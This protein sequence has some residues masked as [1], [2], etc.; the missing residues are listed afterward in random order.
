[1]QPHIVIN[2]R[3]GLPADWD[4]PEQEIG[5]FQNNRAWESCITL[6]QQW[7]WKPDD[8]M[9]PLKQCIETLVRCA[10]GDGNLLLNVGP[11]PTGEIEPRQVARLKE[12]GEWTRQYGSSIYGTRG[13]PFKPGPWGGSTYRGNSIYLHVL[14][15]PEGGLKLPPIKPSITSSHVLSGG[16][17]VL[18]Q[19]DQQITVTLPADSQSALDTVIELKLDGP[20]SEIA[21]LSL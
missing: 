17:A 3:A 21:P 9:K 8:Q 11:M 15:W 12:I 1:L 19:T 18:R 6:C 20:A 13:G 16:T 10:G 2:N 14:T 4:T 7:A 5:K